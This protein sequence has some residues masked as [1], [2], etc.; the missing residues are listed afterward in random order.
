MKPKTVLVTG[1]AGYIGSHT[2]LELLNA[3]YGLAVLDNYTNSEPE[4]LN[5]V[6]QISNSDFKIYNA[7]IRDEK[8]LENVFSFERIDAVIHF[9]ALKAVAESVR[10]PLD[11]YETNVLGTINLCKEM[12]RANCMHIVFSS[13]ATVYGLNNPSPYIEEYPLNAVN[14]YGST[15]VMVERI[16][17]DISKSNPMWSAVML[18]Y[19]NPIG[20]HSSGLLGEKPSGIPNNIMPYIT[21]V[22]A[23]R[24]SELKIFGGD[25]PTADG[26]GVRDYIH[27]VDIAKGH[28]AALEYAF[29]H[30]GAEAINLG[31]GKG[32]SVLELVHAFEQ[33]SGLSIPYQIT[34]RRQGDLAAYYADT[35]KAKELLGWKAEYSIIKMCEDAWRFEQREHKIK[36]SLH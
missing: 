32:T 36:G 24:L 2:C 21:G 35:K 15:K 16:L 17:E 4:M 23:G 8:A 18:R 12:Q 19:F 13:S 27:V 30:K 6:K 26:T 20:A 3:G 1:G 28:L 25:Y 34:E 14:P 33:A 10:N 29:L 31:T 7:D 11:Y 9:A 22:A 5:R